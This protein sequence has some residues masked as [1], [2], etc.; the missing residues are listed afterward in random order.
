MILLVKM[1]A[2]STGNGVTQT[3]T[4]SGTYVLRLRLPGETEIDAEH[5]VHWTPET[6]DNEHMNKFKSN[7]CCV[8]H[9]PRAFDSS[10]S[11]SDGSDTESDEEFNKKYPQFASKRYR[12]N[13][14]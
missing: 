8:F 9:K 11:E 6:V 10:D 7:K 12:F 14:F 4:D 13:L 2:L 3:E 1:E 5:H